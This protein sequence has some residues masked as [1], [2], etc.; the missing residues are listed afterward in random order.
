MAWRGR[1][2][3]L[4]VSLACASLSSRPNFISK[5]QHFFPIQ[6]YTEAF[7]HR[8]L[9]NPEWNHECQMA[10]LVA[11]RN[12]WSIYEAETSITT[13]GRL[14]SY[15]HCRLWIQDP[16]CALNARH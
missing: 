6:S 2:R 7:K 15:T 1:G 4:Q 13:R 8:H 16:Q 11:Q 9:V 3:G 14:T 5:S 12:H 10:Q